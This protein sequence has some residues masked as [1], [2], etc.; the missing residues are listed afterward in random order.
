M[1]TPIAALRASGSVRRH[2]SGGVAAEMTARERDREMRQKKVIILSPQ[3]KVVLGIINNRSLGIFSY[4]S[5]S[6]ALQRMIPVYGTVYRLVTAR[7]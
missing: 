1:E 7:R 2:I 5:T 6:M 3:T 4:F